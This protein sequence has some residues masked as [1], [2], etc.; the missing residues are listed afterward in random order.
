MQEPNY[1]HHRLSNEND[2]LAYLKQMGDSEFWEYL[3]KLHNKIY[4]MQPGESFVVD[5]VVKEE[6]KDL[7]IKLLCFF[8]AEYPAKYLFNETYTVFYKLK[9]QPIFHSIYEE[10]K[11]QQ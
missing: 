6:N 1:T 4:Y 7:F 10:S 5:D 3:T 9:P 11:V 8:I 2:L